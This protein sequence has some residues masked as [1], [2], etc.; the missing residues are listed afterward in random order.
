ML[1]S[2]NDAAICLS[3][4]IGLMQF[5]KIKNKPFSPHEE[6]WYESYLS[7]TNK[8]FS[9]LFINLMNEKCKNIGLRDT[10]LY[11]S[12]GNDAYDQLKN[13]STCN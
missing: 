4:A 5:L 6:N 2:G 3:E 10:H 13:V 8:N 1:P 9:Y 11:N 7:N 12:H